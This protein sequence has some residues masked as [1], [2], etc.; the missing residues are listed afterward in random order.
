MQGQLE[1]TD[2]GPGSTKAQARDGT[3]VSQAALQP[4]VPTAPGVDGSSISLG[5]T[6][7]GK[8]AKSQ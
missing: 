7:G 5:D 3:L 1:T 2:S 6:R 4:P 8:V